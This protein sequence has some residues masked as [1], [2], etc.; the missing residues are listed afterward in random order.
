MVGI[1]VLLILSFMAQRSQNK[2]END[3]NVWNFLKIK[4][5][6]WSENFF[7]STRKAKEMRH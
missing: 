5:V 7:L 3:Y 2:S 1:W 6:I 4:L